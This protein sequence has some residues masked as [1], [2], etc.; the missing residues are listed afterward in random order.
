[1]DSKFLEFWGNYMLAAAKGQQQI[2]DLYKWMEQGFSGFK[3]L[4][5]TFRD[6]YDLD[7]N[8]RQNGDSDDAWQT[9]ADGFRNSYEAYLNLIGAVSKQKFREL[10]QKVVA[11]E[12][13][14]A[15]RDETITILR[16]LLAE[17]GTYQGET[18]KALQDLVNKQAGAFESFM[19]S[20]SDTGK[21]EK[22]ES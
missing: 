16:D 20:I 8:R 13:K 9:A 4:T 19:K 3:D 6:Y 22:E 2:D 18:V 7:S 11:L 15:E 10:E 1:M 17:K 21:E 14:L 5:A 12:E